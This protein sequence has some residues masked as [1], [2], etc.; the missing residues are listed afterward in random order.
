MKTVNSKI[1]NQRKLIEKKLLSWQAISH[2]K[3]PPSGW[4]KAIRMSL[5][6]TTSQLAKLMGINQATALR[7]EKREAEGKITLETL[8]KAAE[9]MNCKLVY[10]LV[11]R[12]PHKSLNDILNEKATELAFSILSRTEH[13]MQLE[14]QGTGLNKSEVKELAEDLVN[15]LDKRIWNKDERN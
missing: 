7:Y 9:A 3:K 11:P 2:D 8:R 12:E 10:A 4:V 13:S 15:S 6:M 14:K 5:G 1:L